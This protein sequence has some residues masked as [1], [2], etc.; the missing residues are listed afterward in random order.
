MTKDFYSQA[1]NSN[2]DRMKR[3]SSVVHTASSGG[4]GGMPDLY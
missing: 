2:R 1:L 3:L 4:E